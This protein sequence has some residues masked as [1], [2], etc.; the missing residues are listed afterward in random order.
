MVTGD[1]AR[2][3]DFYVRLSIDSEGADS[4]ER[5]ER[6]LREWAER[7][8]LEVRRVWRDQ[9]KSGYRN[10]KRV[11]FDSALKAVTAREVGTLAVWK[12]DRLSRKGAGQVGLFLDDVEAVGGRLI[13]LKDGLDTR[14]M[15]NAG[16]IPIMVLSELARAESVNTSLRVKSRKDANRADGRYLGGPPPYGYEVDADRHFVPKEPEFS[17]MREAVRRV[18]EGDSLLKVCR[19]FNARGIPTRR[20]GQWRVNTLSASLRSPGLSGLMPEKVRADDGSWVSKVEAWRNP[21]TGETVSLMADGCEPIASEAEQARVLAVMD[22]RLRQY[23]RGKQVV[24]Q[25]VSLLGGLLVCAS[26]KRKAHT[27]GNSYRCR[28]WSVDGNDCS[29]PLNVSTGVVESAV[30]R[31]WAGKLAAL[32]DEP[33]SPLL[34]AVAARWLERNDPGPMREREE[35]QIQVDEAR[36]RM[37]RA[38]EDHYVKGTLDVARHARITARLQDEVARL[39]ARLADLPEPTADLGGL[40]DPELSLPAFEA[41]SVHEKR[42][43]LRLAIERVEV[44]AAPKRGARFVPTERMSVKW[45]DVV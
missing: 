44:T 43:L 21:E 31:A 32:D 1:P 33:D 42:E 26:C 25:P 38:D 3:V 12:L 11:G 7:E 39:V 18:Q 17:V 45:A 35:L 16:R 41:S 23:G 19:D 8:G 15:G 4:L 28:K 6:D 30:I 13:S 5:Q 9:G 27:F 10:V 22:S 20:G 14:T 34:Q 36:A 24:R 29:A 2:L 37:D 40:L